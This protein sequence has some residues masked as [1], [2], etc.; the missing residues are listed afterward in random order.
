MV[1][2]KQECFLGDLEIVSSVQLQVE[3]NLQNSVSSDSLVLSAL[4]GNSTIKI[5][6]K[7]GESSIAFSTIETV[8]MAVFTASSFCS[9][10]SKSSIFVIL[11]DGV[12]TIR[13]L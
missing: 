7:D 12:S 4:G 1:V 11:F 10:L 5:F 13:L 6:Y 8:S 9:S 2:R 3:L